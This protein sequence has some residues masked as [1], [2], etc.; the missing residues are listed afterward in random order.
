MPRISQLTEV[1][2]ITDAAT[3]IILDQG[4]TKRI[5]Y[6]TFRSTGLKGDT[7][8]TGTRG[9]QGPI[10]PTGT[11]A[12]IQIG[13]VTAGANAAVT[14]VGNS[15]SA[16]LNFVLPYGPKGDTG[17]Y[18]PVIASTSTLGGVKIGTGISISVDGTI[19]ATTATPYTLPNATTSTLG[20]IKLGEGLISAGNGVVSATI[21]TLVT[22]TSVRLGGVKIGPG[23]GVSADG[24]ISVTTGAFALQTA[25]AGILGGIKIGEGLSI[26][27]DGVASVK[28]A[29]AGSIGGVIVG[30]GLTV[31]VNGIVMGDATSLQGGTLASNVTA[32]SLTS[33]GDLVGLTVSGTTVLQQTLEVYTSITGASSSV[34]HDYSTGAVFVHNSPAGNFTPNFTNVPVNGSRVATM[35]LLINQG[36]TPVIPNAMRVNSVTQTIKWQGGIVPT[37]NA[38]KTDLVNFTVFLSAGTSTFTVLGSLSSFG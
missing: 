34:T 11:A 27:G 9:L 29:T 20:G 14:N 19:S 4:E 38:N 30:Q 24:T 2:T 33:L 6:R 17:T 22:A 31:D 3:L 23:I 10:G 21:Y 18:V 13:V 8:D 26:D 25:S 16:V 5:S 32:S 28:P 15:G 36:V 35:A 37:G 7:G 12:T 1:T